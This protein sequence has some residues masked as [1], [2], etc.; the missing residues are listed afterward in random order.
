MK[1]KKEQ[2]QYIWFFL[3]ELTKE[4]YNREN[5]KF[6]MSKN[7]SP[8]TEINM[9]DLNYNIYTDE[10]KE[11]GT[12]PFYRF[13]G[14]LNDFLNPELDMNPELFGEIYNILIHILANIDLQEGLNKKVII[15][16]LLINRIESGRYGE[17]I[18]NLFEVLS[19]EEKTIIADGI[20]D[21]YNSSKELEIFKKV[22]RKIY[23]DSLIYDM[24]ENEKKVIIYINQKKTKNNRKKIK[25]I[26]SFF[27]PVGLK[28]YCFWEKHFGIIGVD[29]T[30][31][32][33]EVAVF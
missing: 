4:N 11:I 32:I 25:L 9:E 29:E 31:K 21:K 24:P 18:Q 14:V 15:S 30:M 16:R 1:I 10:K 17:E 2:Y 3:Q 33:G 20:Q 5:L 12:N 7:L 13:T 23:F 26:K 19:G 8:Y 6:V 22:V 28:T 27:L